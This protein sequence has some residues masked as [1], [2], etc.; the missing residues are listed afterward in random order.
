MPIVIVTLT[1]KKT[2]QQKS[3][4]CTIYT[5]PY[6]S[7]APIFVLIFLCDIRGYLSRAFD[8]STV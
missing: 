1:L 5:Y 2:F 4:H 3:A 8:S 7:Y 6:S